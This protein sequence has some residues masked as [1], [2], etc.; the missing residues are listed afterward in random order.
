LLLVY[1]C[2][3]TTV[4]IIIIIIIYLLNKTI[5][6]AVKSTIEQD[7]KAKALTAAQKRKLHRNYTTNKQ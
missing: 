4:I 3:N 5:K 6:C 7:S 1:F 2:R